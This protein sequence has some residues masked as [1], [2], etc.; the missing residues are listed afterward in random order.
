MKIG[1]QRDLKLIK[2]RQV[3]QT[4]DSILTNNGN[5]TTSDSTSAQI[6]VQ[7]SPNI[8]KSLFVDQKSI[9]SLIFFTLKI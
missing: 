2:T 1:H 9:F 8:Q 5:D 6:I 3:D 4:K 7:S